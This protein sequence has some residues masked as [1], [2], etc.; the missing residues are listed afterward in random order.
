MCQ[1]KFVFGVEGQLKEESSHTRFILVAEF[2]G[3]KVLGSL[4]GTDPAQR[5]KSKMVL[6][7]IPPVTSKVIGCRMLAT[8]GPCACFRHHE[9]E[10]VFGPLLPPL[11]QVGSI[12]S[13]FLTFSSL[14]ASKGWFRVICFLSRAFALGANC[15]SKFKRSTAAPPPTRAALNVLKADTAPTQLGHGFTLSYNCLAC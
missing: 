1:P 11:R 10:E 9:P 4:Q 5:S 6:N 2:G 8:T 7:N 13:P 3:T 14:F 12:V 15:T